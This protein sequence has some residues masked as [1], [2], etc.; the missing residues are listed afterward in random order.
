MH[1]ISIGAAR[2]HLADVTSRVV[3]RGERILLTRF[4]RDFAALVRLWDFDAPQEMED[5]RVRAAAPKAGV[6]ISKLI[7]AET[8][9]EPVVP[10]EVDVPPSGTTG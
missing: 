4:G 3:Y 8:A 2:A 6:P 7:A 9:K 1:G 5:E 10:C